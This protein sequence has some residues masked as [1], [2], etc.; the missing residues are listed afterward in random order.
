MIAELEQENQAAGAELAEARKAA[1]KRYVDCVVPCAE[2]ALTLSAR[3]EECQR[4]LS[5]MIGGVAKLQF[6]QSR[7]GKPN[8]A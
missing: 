4:Q 2:L 8:D 5:D 7:P 6:A 1:G 3:T